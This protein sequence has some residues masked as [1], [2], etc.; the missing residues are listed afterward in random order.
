MT[1]F[2]K[3]VQGL[4]NENVP[5]N[6]KL[7]DNGSIAV[8]CGRNYPDE[9]FFQVDNVAE[10]LGI[11]VDVCAEVYGGVVETQQRVA[12]GPKRYSF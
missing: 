4:Q 2:Q 10:K 12:G 5:C 3:L 7:F 8:E 9:M 11:K 6:V 1:N